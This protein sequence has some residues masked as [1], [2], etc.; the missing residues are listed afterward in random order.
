M[1]ESY[2]AIVLAGAGSARLDGADKAMIDVGGLAMIDRVLAGL[3]EASAVAVV[4]PERPVHRTVIWCQ[5][6]PIGA[7]PVAAFAAGL[8]KLVEIDRVMLLAA[9][10]P[11]VGPAIPALL[12]ALSGDVAVLVDANGRMNFLAS[13]WRVESARARLAELGEVAGAPMR[14]LFDGLAI[15]QVPD[16]DAWSTD[17][18]TWDAIE[19]ARTR[20]ITDGRRDG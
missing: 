2:A 12:E 11:F 6:D 1:S 16:L 7:G 20:A 5:E 17:C 14:R 8:D 18:D 10:L 15:D 4:G 9:D 19:S 3:A 13:A